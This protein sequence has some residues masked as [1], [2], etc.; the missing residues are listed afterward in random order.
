MMG[1]ILEPE[2]DAIF[3]HFIDHYQGPLDNL[4]IDFWVC[5]KVEEN[6]VS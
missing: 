5:L 6:V 1:D 3:I 2:V 4:A